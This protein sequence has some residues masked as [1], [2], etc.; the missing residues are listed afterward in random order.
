[1]RK[2]LTLLAVTVLLG[3]PLSAAYIVVLKDGTKY[4]AVAKWTMQGN[5]ALI[6]LT[7]GQQLTVDPSLIDAAKSEQATRYG[8]ASVMDEGTV[9]TQTA[10]PKQQQPSL[11]SSGCAAAAHSAVRRLRIPPHNSRRP[12]GRRCRR[13]PSPISSTDV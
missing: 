11:G 3:S 9:Q 12:A 8:T 5:K 2:A 1:M 7:N 10:A 6:K 4:Q 13:K